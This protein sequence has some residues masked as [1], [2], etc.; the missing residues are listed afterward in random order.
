MV[1]FISYKLYIAVNQEDMYSI[2]A[3][4]DNVALPERFARNQIV[5]NEVK[6]NPL[7]DFSFRDRYNLGWIRDSKVIIKSNFI[8]VK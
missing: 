2:I 6:N 7:G 4:G 1:A 5:F 3:K 8:R